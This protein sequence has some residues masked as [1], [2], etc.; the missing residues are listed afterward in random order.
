MWAG[1][2][3]T[4]NKESQLP[5]INAK[6]VMTK[7]REY[8]N[9]VYERRMVY[10]IELGDVEDP[11]IYAA[12]PLLDWQASDHGQWVMAHGLDPTYHMQADYMNYGYVIKVTAYITPKRWTEYCLRF[13]K[14]V[15]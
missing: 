6:R 11:E 15:F 2:T 13:D 8:N 7:Y 14:Y 1:Q 5:E 4:F 12:Q 9:E 3:I 10:K